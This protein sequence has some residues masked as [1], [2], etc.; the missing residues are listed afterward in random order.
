MV[1]PV[2]FISVDY[3]CGNPVETGTLNLRSFTSFERSLRHPETI[4]CLVLW[5]THP[6]LHTSV[7]TAYTFCFWL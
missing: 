4:A 6:F 7:Q 5:M 1:A 3:Y 2:T